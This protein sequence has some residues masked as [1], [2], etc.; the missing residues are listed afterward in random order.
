MAR[1]WRS[2]ARWRLICRRDEPVQQEDPS[3]VRAHF[4]NMKMKTDLS[5]IKGQ[6]PSSETLVEMMMQDKKMRD[7]HL[8]FIL[9]RGIGEA[10]VTAD[11]DLDLVKTVLDD[12]LK[13]K[14]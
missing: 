3:R 5:D 12:A 8:H 2:A 9:A 14:G 6:L 7:G 4:K 13:A 11:V 10:F 1:V